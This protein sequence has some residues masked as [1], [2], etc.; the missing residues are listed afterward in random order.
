M[1]PSLIHLNIF[2]FE[3]EN[4]KNAA[5][6]REAI[7][8]LLKKKTP[9]TQHKRKWP[10]IDTSP[11]AHFH[12]QWG[13]CS[14][15]DAN[16]FHC[17]RSNHRARDAKSATPPSEKSPVRNLV[18]WGATPGSRQTL[19]GLKSRSRLWH[20]RFI[21]LRQYS[22]HGSDEQVLQWVNPHP[23]TSLLFHSAPND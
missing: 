20:L 1:F 5:S 13:S 6:C 7:R 19:F 12:Q 23:A 15:W 11:R 21:R 22:G 4:E 2:P 10:T 16:N 8:K 17:W 14:R 3:R 18:A 9:L